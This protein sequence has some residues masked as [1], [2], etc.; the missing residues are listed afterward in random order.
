MIEKALT[1][2]QVAKQVGAAPNTI[3]GY[4]RDFGQLLSEGA[5]PKPG[6]ERKYTEEQAGKIKPMRPFYQTPYLAGYD[7]VLMQAILAN[8]GEQSGEG[9]LDFSKIM[10]LMGQSGQGQ[11]TQGQVTPQSRQLIQPRPGI[12]G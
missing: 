9:G 12:G 7:K 6:Q 10:E 8:L 5:T 1:V 2:S 3:R 4:S 11:I